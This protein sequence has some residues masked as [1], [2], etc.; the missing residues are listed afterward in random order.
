MKVK[1]SISM[2]KSISIPLLLQGRS[3]CFRKKEAKKFLNICFWFYALKLNAF[4]WRRLCG[5]EKCLTKTR[6]MFR[7]STAIVG[8]QK[9]VAMIVFYNIIWLTHYIWLFHYFGLV[10]HC[11]H[12]IATYA[13][14]TATHLIR[15]N[16]TIIII[17]IIFG[18]SLF[19]FHSFY[20]SKTSS[21]ENENLWIYES[22]VV[23]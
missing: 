6:T 17:I 14:K 12:M 5:S 18:C 8:N 1:P 20:M 4:R 7:L 13:N 3:I 15:Y 2:N 19:L 22:M 21:I 11:F 10:V 9:F 16:P 23:K